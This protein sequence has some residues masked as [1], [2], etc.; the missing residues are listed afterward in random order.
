MPTKHVIFNYKEIR[1][2]QNSRR[3][4]CMAGQTMAWPLPDDP[5]GI[6]HSVPF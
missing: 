4:D 1:M 2:C 6:F 5:V 3:Q